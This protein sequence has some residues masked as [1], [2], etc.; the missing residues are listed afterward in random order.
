MVPVWTYLFYSNNT[1][2]GKVTVE[3]ITEVPT[4][5]KR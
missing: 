5:A 2:T 3:R 4:A 1:G